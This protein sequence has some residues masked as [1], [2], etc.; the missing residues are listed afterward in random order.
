M[1]KNLLIFYVEKFSTKICRF[2]VKNSTHSS[3]LREIPGEGG[4]R[5]VLRN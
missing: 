1:K 3:G 5:K 2:Y 4:G